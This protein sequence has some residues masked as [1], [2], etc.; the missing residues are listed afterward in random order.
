MLL[1]T[2]ITQNENKF[3][4]TVKL[5][6]IQYNEKK[7]TLSRKL[8]HGFI[9][10]RKIYMTFKGTKIIPLLDNQ[11]KKSLPKLRGCYV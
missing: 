4:L 3:K 5:I 6:N 8:V 9:L 1:L 2:R 10:A 7:L 11:I